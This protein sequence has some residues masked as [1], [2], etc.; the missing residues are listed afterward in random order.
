MGNEFTELKR[1]VIEELFEDTNFDLTSLQRMDDDGGCQLWW[2]APAG[3]SGNV[4]GGRIDS[5]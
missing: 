1:L 3:Q 2:Y 4:E 5:L